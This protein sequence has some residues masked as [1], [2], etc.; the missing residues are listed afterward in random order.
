[1][2]VS[3]VMTKSPECIAPN[4]TVQEA[5]GRMKS[6]DVGSL[7][8]C[9]ND[10]L[11]G[12]ITDRDIALRSVAEGHDPRADPVRDTM[13]PGIVYCYDDQDA[14]E[15]AKL[16]SEKQIRRLPV[17]DRNKRLVGIVSLGDLAVEARDD[18]MTG[19]ALKHISEPS[20]PWR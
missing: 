15:A 1:M 10:R 7:P 14:S 8:V 18:N 13:T 6:L 16:M 19:D 17:L 20:D 4:A 2:R 11:V 3:E 9:D 5:A 12:V